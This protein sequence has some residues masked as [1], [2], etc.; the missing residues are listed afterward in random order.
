MSA[1]LGTS[2]S[3]VDISSETGV[4]R[5]PTSHAFVKWRRGLLT[6]GPVIAAD[7][8]AAFGALLVVDGALSVLG[9]A[10]FSF[11]GADVLSL[12]TA[13][14]LSQ[15]LFGLYRE[16]VWGPAVELRSTTAASSPIFIAFLLIETTRGDARALATF[17]AWL[18]CLVSIPAVRWIVRHYLSGHEWWGQPVLMCGV[19]PGAVGIYRSLERNRL[20]GLRP[21]GLIGP[22]ESATRDAHGIPVIP[23]DEVSDFVSERQVT[24]MIVALSDC[25]DVS[26]SRLVHECRQRVPNCLIV[27]DLSGVP[28]LWSTV[29][30]C[31]GRLGLRS[32]DN[33]RRSVPRFVKQLMDYGITSLVFVATLPVFAVIAALVKLGSPGPIIYA[34]KCLGE[35]GR[36]FYY[37]KFRTMVPNADQALKRYLEEHPEAREE[38]SRDQKLKNDPRVTPLGRFLRKTSLDELPQLWNVLRGEMSL[39][40]PRPIVD[41]EIAKYGAL[42]ELRSRVRPGITGLWQ[43][44]G[45]STT[46]YAERIA[47][48]TYYVQNWSP[49]LDLYILISTIR[50]VL[51]QEGAV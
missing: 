16:G 5:R 29:T 23:W 48:D 41:N 49:W 11:V 47:L 24:T 36:Y 17:A 28:S 32:V 26:A 10:H 38:W 14:V 30:E 4:E 42:F 25:T 22:S 50:V 8:V 12:C 19:G 20:S 1:I 39:V 34:R 2:E 46:T 44:S 31:G 3:G 21:I 15:A 51:F 7:F 45:R 40:G 27:P 43:V 37:L 13:V 9:F 6:T 33:L 35:H 18:G